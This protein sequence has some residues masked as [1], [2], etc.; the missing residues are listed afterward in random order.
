MNNDIF[1]AF[2]IKLRDAALGYRIEYPNVNNDTAVNG[3]MYLR[4]THFPNR[5]IDATH[6]DQFVI[7]QGLFQVE[8][9]GR[10]KIGVNV[11]ND[12]ASAVAAV[13][14]KLTVLSNVIVNRQPYISSVVD[15]D[16]HKA[17]MPLTIP[18]SG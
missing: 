13:F 2:M 16:G 6:A 4:V 12:A 5:G 10:S 11:F 7:R 17:S 15:I 9:V 3:E 14:P 1:D 8:V 18:Y